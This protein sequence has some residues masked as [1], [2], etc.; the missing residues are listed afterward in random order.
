MIPR[1]LRL[2]QSDAC[3]VSWYTAELLGF[4]SLR[5]TILRTI[6]H[7]ATATRDADAHAAALSDAH[8]TDARRIDAAWRLWLASLDPL[9]RPHLLQPT[10]LAALQPM[11]AL[12]A[13]LAAKLAASRVVRS[14]ALAAA[15]H[16]TAVEA[17]ASTLVAVVRQLVGIAG[18]QAQAPVARAA[19]MSAVANLAAA[20]GEGLCR[21]AVC[22]GGLDAARALMQ[23]DSLPGQRWGAR[24]VVAVAQHAAECGAQGASGDRATSMHDVIAEDATEED[25]TG[26][27]TTSS[28]QPL[29]ATSPRAASLIACCQAAAH[30]AR[31]ADEQ[32][33]EFGCHALRA[34]V[35]HS[36]AVR[37]WLVRH[38]DEP[39]ASHRA[40]DV[41][42][43]VD[44][45]SLLAQRRPKH[46]DARRQSLDDAR[47]HGALAAPRSVR[48]RCSVDVPC[49]PIAVV[50]PCCPTTG[51]VLALM[52]A[53]SPSVRLHACRLLDALLH[54][55]PSA[56]HLLHGSARQELVPTPAP[57]TLRALCCQLADPIEGVQ[58]QAAR[59]LLQA[60]RLLQG[61][62]VCPVHGHGALRGVLRLLASPSGACGIAV[63]QTACRGM[64][65]RGGLLSHRSV[66]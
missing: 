55:A 30:V 52:H 10:I 25:A 3:V 59:V 17:C 23:H 40:K 54:D 53:Q 34:L 12:G 43:G 33:Q 2:L 58:V 9:Q 16:P 61:V 41:D 31:Q 45:C 46:N 62:V 42:H 38:V 6:L 51:G 37:Q 60:C 21:L 4:L 14:I 1:L 47:G 36:E 18:D 27:C 57:P 49:K 29:H 39:L 11:L 48:R 66:T 15:S 8:A 5:D 35:L 24:L 20:G 56:R 32:C 63:L 22:H 13:S 44:Q 50:P 28:T 19:A 7:A 65:H 64:L 26:S